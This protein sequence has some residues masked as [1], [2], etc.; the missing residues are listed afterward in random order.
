MD[1]QL[2]ARGVGPWRA[3]R[4][5][6]ALAALLAA[7][8]ASAQTDEIQVYTGE[9]AEPGELGLALHAN[10]VVSGK[11]RPRFPEGIVPEG[12]VNGVLELAL[13]VAPW[14]EAGLYLPVFTLTRDGE[15]LF[16]GAK[17]RALFVTPRAE[18]RR[19]SFG[20][21]FELSSN[22]SHWDPS[23]FTSEARFIL[24]GRFGAL[25]VMLNPILETGF[26]GFGAIVLAPATRVGYRLS[27]RWTVAIEHH[28]DLGTL[29]G[30]DPASS[31]NEHA[32]F[33]VV[34]HDNA[35]AD[36]ELGIGFGLTPA[37]DAIT[38]K[39]ILMPEL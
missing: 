6:V 3:T 17:L 13:G 39:L 16:D 37:T 33:A 31:Q 12:A 9:I 4:G 22:A 26:D 20:V 15:V 28:A 18:E 8:A 7:A 23:R 24:A 21:N 29:R 10:Y 2:N 14:A 25:E 36:V 30:L 19:L 34:D 35:L 11:T 5:A 27:E 32:L 38:L 1:D